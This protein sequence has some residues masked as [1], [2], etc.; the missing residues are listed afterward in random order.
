MPWDADRYADHIT[1]LQTGF[2]EAAETRLTNRYPPLY[3]KPYPVIIEPTTIT[4]KH[5]NCLV[6]HLPGI[7]SPERQVSVAGANSGCPTIINPV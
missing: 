4:D 3:Q 2:N 7:V 6:W 5:G 1:P